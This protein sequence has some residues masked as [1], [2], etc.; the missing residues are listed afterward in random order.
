MDFLDLGNHCCRAV[1]LLTHFT[2]KETKWEADLS[3][4]LEITLPWYTT[5]VSAWAPHTKAMLIYSLILLQVTTTKN[6]PKKTS[7]SIICQ[8]TKGNGEL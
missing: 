6:I 3:A 8:T 4:F 7:P 1:S 2:D 5:A